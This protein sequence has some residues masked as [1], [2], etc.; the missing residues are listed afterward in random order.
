MTMMT[1]IDEE[2]NRHVAN[3]FDC[4]EYNYVYHIACRRTEIIAAMKKR[5][6]WKDGTPIRLESD[7]REWITMMRC[8]N[9]QPNGECGGHPVVNIANG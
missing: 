5:S 3:C 9:Q 7:P 1:E 8:N 4:Q 2:F 6:P